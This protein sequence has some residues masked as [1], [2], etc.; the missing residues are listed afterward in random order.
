MNSHTTDTPAVRP[1]IKALDQNDTVKES[2]EHSANE[3]LVANAVLKT[4]IPDHAQNSD[5]V[6][7]LEKSRV[8]EERIQESVDELAQVNA[9]LEREVDERIELERQL[10]ATQAALAKTRSALT[11]QIEASTNRST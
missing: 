1:L 3:L 5:V 2:V 6:H 9:L 7:A 10:L 8:V 11:R 4:E